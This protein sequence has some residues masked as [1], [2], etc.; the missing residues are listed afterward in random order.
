[1]AISKRIA[2]V[3]FAKQATKGTG[4]GT[5]LVGL[6]VTGGSVLSV[7]IE[8]ESDGVT[9]VSSRVAADE[10]RIAITPGMVV[11]ARAYARSIGLLLLGALGGDVVTGTNPYV[12]T[13]TPAA[14]LPYLTGFAQY[15]VEYDKVV[16]L[17]VD[18]LTLSWSERRPL[19]VTAT[20]L[21]ITPTFGTSSWTATNDDT[22]AARFMP[23]GGVFKVDAG[24]GTAV[25]AKITGGTLS[26]S[27]NLD[28]VPLS[29][30]VVP[31]E[32]FEG[33]QAIE[34]SLSLQPDDLAEW[35]KV[36]T[37]TGTGTAI[38]ATPVYGSFDELFTI[39]ASNYL[40]IAAAR[41][42]FMCDFPDADP[43]GGAA[44]ITLVGRVKKP[45]GVALTAVVKN[46][47]AAY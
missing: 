39:D 24:S 30:A 46:T 20:L 6:P 36:V 3:G 5:P 27:N 34:M 14:A 26:I 19:D 40:Q 8:Q 1:M 44:E 43:A 4:I 42:A 17:K 23:P 35:K 25:V 38:Q 41:V 47:V 7:A 13:I 21:G 33:E 16:D 32:V 11:N 45:A 15:G 28:G 18:Q 2:A 31:D 9:N 29:V 10:D 12:H 22:G 37:G